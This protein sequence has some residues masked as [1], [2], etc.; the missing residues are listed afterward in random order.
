M[1]MHLLQCFEH[2][3]TGCKSGPL[4]PC[5]VGFRWIMLMFRVIDLFK[6]KLISKCLDNFNLLCNLYRCHLLKSSS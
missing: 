4:Y 6:L 1:F 2:I 3:L 5:L